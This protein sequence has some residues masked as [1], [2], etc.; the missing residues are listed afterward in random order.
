MAY[1]INTVWL[2]LVNLVVVGD[3]IYNLHRF[4]PGQFQAMKYFITNNRNGNR[5][6][7]Y[8]F[9]LCV[10]IMVIIYVKVRIV[11][12]NVVYELKL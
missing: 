5:Y 9:L 2:D 4:G 10:L 12:F 1:V 11:D 8:G 7:L 6:L 3:W